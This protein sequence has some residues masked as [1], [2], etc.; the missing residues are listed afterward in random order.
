MSNYNGWKNYETW[1]VAL[2]F[3]NDEGLYNITKHCANYSD[4][5]SFLSDCGVNKTPDG[6]S[7]TNKKLDI[8]ALDE[9][10]QENHS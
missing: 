4:F 10:I 2:W 6:V 3:N 5:I 8:E 1:N 7:Y 9:A